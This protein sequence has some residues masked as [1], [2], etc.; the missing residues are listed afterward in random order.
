M[1]LLLAP[2]LDAKLLPPAMALPPF[3]VETALLLL[4]P[5]TVLPALLVFAVEFGSVL[6]LAVDTV[7][8]DVEFGCCSKS[9]AGGSTLGGAG[10]TYG[11]AVVLLLSC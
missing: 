8:D 9:G 7:D 1:L 5:V 3:T 6:I 4:P 10:A 2:L 11:D